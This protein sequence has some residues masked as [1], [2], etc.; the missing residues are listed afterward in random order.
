MDTDM[1]SRCI[2]LFAKCQK[3]GI[4][5]IEHF[6]DNNYHILDIE[7]ML[8]GITYEIICIYDELSQSYVKIIW[9]G[10]RFPLL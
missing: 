10:S 1:Q 6:R 2:K 8:D 9:I 5:E 4:K 7:N 3:Y